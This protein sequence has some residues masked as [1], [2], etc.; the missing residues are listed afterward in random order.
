MSL[1]VEQQKQINVYL[2]RNPKVSREQ[3]IIHLFGWEGTQCISTKG[4]EVESNGA[5]KATSTASAVLVKIG[6]KTYNLNKTIELR[7]NNV[8]RNLKK[9]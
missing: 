1:S 9:A 5:K 3:A 6:D 4:L 8:S 2:K 7:I